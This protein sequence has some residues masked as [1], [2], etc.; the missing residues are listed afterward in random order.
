MSAGPPPIVPAPQPLPDPPA[1]T[2][3]GNCT[4]NGYL[5]S[6]CCCMATGRWFCR[7]EGGQPT[8][9][10]LCRQP[11]PAA[12]CQCWTPVSP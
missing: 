10:Q 12:E 4:Q 6:D 2:C 1:G 9:P 3:T 11:E 8:K 5:P 7:S